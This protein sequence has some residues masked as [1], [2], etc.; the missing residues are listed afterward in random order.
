MIWFILTIATIA[1]QWFYC[2]L[3]NKTIT[4]AK[5]DN[6]DTTTLPYDREQ[7]QQLL[8]KWWGVI[9]VIAY[10]GLFA[11]TALTIWAI[12]VRITH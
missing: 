10:I 8:I 12:I 7:T 11:Y 2:Q 4:F 5:D 3:I 1:I 9:R 6:A